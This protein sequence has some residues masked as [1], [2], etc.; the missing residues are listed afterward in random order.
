MEPFVARATDE[1]LAD[2]RA[3]LRA[4]RWPDAPGDA[5]WSLGVDVD[6]LRELPRDE[7]LSTVD[8]F[9]KV[10]ATVTA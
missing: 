10:A 9:A 7:A 2:L 5:E 1:E 4:T 8:E 3:R 6:Y